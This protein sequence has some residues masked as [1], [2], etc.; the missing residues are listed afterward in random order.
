MN[1][2]Q[3]KPPL[4]RVAGPIAALVCV[5]AIVIHALSIMKI[6]VQQHFPPVMALHVLIFVCFIPFVLSLNKRF[7][8]CAK[9]AQL[10]TI[11]PKWTL[12][13]SGLI[14]A[15][16]MINFFLSIG[17]LGATPEIRDGQYILHNKGTLVRVITEVEYHHAR[18]LILRMFSG[19][20]IIFS[21][22]PALYFLFAKPAAP[23]N[24]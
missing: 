4:E 23:S 13:L 8:G 7:G 11:L 16:A 2:A 24:P 5:I 19:H 21:G 17:A 14:M 3:A 20:W 1:S 12:I 15:Y 9:L 6:D 22:I 10:A 18:A